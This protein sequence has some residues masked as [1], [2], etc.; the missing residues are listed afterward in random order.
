VFSE[1]GD[2]RIPPVRLIDSW[3]MPSCVEPR[4]EAETQNRVVSWQ[5]A[6]DSTSDL[7]PC[8]SSAAVLTSELTSSRCPDET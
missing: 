2:R 1:R 4:E 7:L 6:N 8:R 5:H 3:Q